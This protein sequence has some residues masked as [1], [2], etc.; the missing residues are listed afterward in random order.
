MTRDELAFAGKGRC[1]RLLVAGVVLTFGLLRT[2]TTEAEEP[3]AWAQGHVADLLPLYHHFHTHPE[4]S[5]QEEQTA[6]RLAD[7]LRKLG[8][9][10]TTK[11]GRHGVVG[12]LRN[13]AGPT[14]M[15]R[16][17]L[18]ALPVTETTGVPYA[19][20]AT[21][22][23]KNGNTVGVMHACGHDI[24]MTCL[25][26]T[27]QYLTQHKSAWKG[28]VMFIG[29]PAE[30]IGGGAIAMLNDGLFRRFG[31]P[32]FALALHVDAALPAGQVGYRA[33]YFL[34]NV[35]SVDITLRGKGGHGAYPH[36]TIDPIVQAAHLII[37]LQTIVSR[38]NSPFEPAVITV[39][40]IRGGNKHNIIP[41]EC[42]L[43]LTVRSYSD[44]VRKKLL[45]GIKRKAKA[46]AEGAGAPEPTVEFS[47]AIPATRNDEDLVARVMPAIERTLG[48]KNVVKLE[49][50]MGGEDF[51][52]YG[53]AGV[54]IFM[55]RLGSIS[56][57]RI[58]EHVRQ[59]KPLPSLHAPEYYPTPEPTIATGVAAMSAAVLDLLASAKKP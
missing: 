8:L 1:V 9:E 24:H 46:V 54:P 55:F 4:L 10:V 20:K 35:D 14:V 48:D 26:G 42:K 37:D 29:Q 25:I 53:L 31:K 5:F 47:D 17:D 58:A 49:L 23:D 43:Q 19:S 11:V 6:A 18:D 16:T 28:T 2:A 36:K 57:D 12:L 41:D 15:V 56:T 34:A 52:Q 39:G 3:R 33:G 22:T 59:E 45:D 51:S 21:G 30:E 50:S 27:A 38:E 44:A 13:G 32:D 40:A 7:E